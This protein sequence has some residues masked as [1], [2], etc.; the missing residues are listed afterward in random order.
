MQTA[1][2]G[3]ESVSCSHEA[4]SCLV[5]P[6]GLM[7]LPQQTGFGSFRRPARGCQVWEQVRG[8]GCSQAMPAWHSLQATSLGH[9]HPPLEGPHSSH[10]S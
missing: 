6:R 4:F 9:R 7:P 10:R 1:G 8:R 2:L 3:S 5:L